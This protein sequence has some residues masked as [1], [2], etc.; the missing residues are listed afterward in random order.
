MSSPG[1]EPQRPPS[2]PPPGWQQP[3][4]APQWPPAGQPPPY[5]PPVSPY[6]A[7]GPPSPVRQPRSTTPWVIGI[8]AA[9][10]AVGVLSVVLVV[11]LGDGS[12]DERSYQEG[13]KAGQTSIVLVEWGGAKPEEVCRNQYSLRTMANSNSDLRRRDY[14]AG[15][16]DA[17]KEELNHK[18]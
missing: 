14:I 18:P 7:F 5:P 13:R 1:W 16:L 15:C 6:G 2:G 3:W 12:R 10:V 11:A 8:I 17:M 9:V 4:P